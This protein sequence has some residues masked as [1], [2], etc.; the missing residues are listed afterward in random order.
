MELVVPAGLEIPYYKK[1]SILFKRAEGVMAVSGA[2]WSSNKT[3]GSSFFG[4]NG[5]TMDTATFERKNS[6]LSIKYLPEGQSGEIL[7]SHM[8]DVICST[9]DIPI[10]CLQAI[11]TDG[12]GDGSKEMRLLIADEVL[13]GQNDAGSSTR[14]EKGPSSDAGGG[15]R[16]GMRM[17]DCSGKIYSCI[18]HRIHL[19]VTEAL[20]G[21]PALK[22]VLVRCRAFVRTVKYSRVITKALR[23][24]FSTSDSGGIRE[25]E[26]VVVKREGDTR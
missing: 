7:K 6:L 5:H 2:R 21:V 12:G 13:E 23:D 11:C 19:A 17:A 9:L 8:K 24:S 26:E 20:K 4:L 3:V 14:G 15:K 22:V 10:K 1:Q 25:K 18:N 16:G